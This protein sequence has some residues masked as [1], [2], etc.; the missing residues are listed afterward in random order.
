MKSSVPPGS[1]KENHVVVIQLLR[2]MKRRLTTGLKDKKGALF[3]CRVLGE[4]TAYPHL[5]KVN[6]SA[7]ENSAS[8]AKKSDSILSQNE[9]PPR[10]ARV[11]ERNRLSGNEMVR[12]TELSTLCQ[13]RFGRERILL[14]SRRKTLW[15]HAA[16][17]N[18]AKAGHIL[19]SRL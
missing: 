3:S 11:L 5:E 8:F 10:L 16:L 14:F 2:I 19:I 15:L 17:H 1:R 6:P 12:D 9:S 13:P 18:E 7:R 4:N